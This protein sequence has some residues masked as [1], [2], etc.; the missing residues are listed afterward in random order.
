MSLGKTVGSSSPK[1]ISP[2]I[3]KFIS[4]ILMISLRYRKECAIIVKKSIFS[5]GLVRIFAIL[6]GVVLVSIG[7]EMFLSPHKI[8]PG[9]IKGIAVLLSHIT[10]MKMGLILLFINLPFVILKKR[11]LKQ[12]I[13]ALVALIV[14]TL[15]TL[16]MYP[17]PPLVNE[18]L[19]ASVC[20]G[21]LFGCGVGLIVRYG[22]YVD[23]VNDVAYYLKKKIRLSIGEILMILNILILTC[24]GFFFGW[25]QAV[26]SIIAYF[27][28]YKSIQFTL[29]YNSRKLICVK[30]SQS[31]RVI[32]LLLQEFGKD[33]EFFTQDSPNQTEIFFSLSKKNTKKL[34]FIIHTLDSSA[35]IEVS[36]ANNAQTQTD[37]YFR[38]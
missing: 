32:E 22:W 17:I 35:N 14:T 33:I 31:R 28:A 13:S 37:F 26:H 11:N 6:L 20:G 24:G 30:T 8:L 36:Y 34:K 21:V 16:L 12:T 23:G 18:P 27:T 38:V 9:G 10:E 15:F 19:L 3:S 1:K 29:E 25:D 5:K 4:G 2:R 7:L